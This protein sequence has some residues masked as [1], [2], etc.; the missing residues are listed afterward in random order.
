MDKDKRAEKM[1]DVIAGEYEICHEGLLGH[2]AFAVVYKG[3]KTK[4]KNFPVAIK[5]ITKKNLNKCQTLL[6]KEIK[7]FKQLTELKNKNLVSMYTCQ[8]T[9]THIYVVME[10]GRVFGITFSFSASY[11]LVNYGYKF[12]TS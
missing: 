5:S 8:E 3:C 1:W 4:D 11:M 12:P 9:P 2:G 10:F 6:T 7:I